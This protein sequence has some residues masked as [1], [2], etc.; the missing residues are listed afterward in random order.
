MPI[1][2]QEDAFQDSSIHG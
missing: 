1:A 2:E